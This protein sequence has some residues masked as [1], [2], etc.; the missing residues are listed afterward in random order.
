MSRVR[1]DDKMFHRPTH[2]LG[3][4]VKIAAG[5]GTVI[6]SVSTPR[7]WFCPSALSSS[8]CKDLAVLVLSLAQLSENTRECS[9][10]Q[11][12]IPM[13]GRVIEEQAQMGES[14]HPCQM[15]PIISPAPLAD[16]DPYLVQEC[17]AFIPAIELPGKPFRISS[18]QKI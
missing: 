7:H 12:R 2:P 4:A 6:S 15:L 18:L 5:A 9:Q 8:P 17:P 13:T 10:C 3:P 1:T 11:W 16:T 14:A